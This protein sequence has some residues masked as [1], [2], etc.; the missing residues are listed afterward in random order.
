MNY[1]IA[2]M[3][4]ATK[5]LGTKEY[6]GKASNAVVESFFARAGHPGLKDDVPWC[7]AFTGAVLAEC[8]VQGS[9]SLMARS[10]LKWGKPV[11]RADA[12][13]GDVV[14]LERGAP[15]SGHVAFFVRW[16]DDKAVLRGGN[17]GDAVNDALF[18]AAKIIG[19]RRADGAMVQTGRPT[20][21]LGDTGL[22]V[23]ELQ[24]LLRER[25]YFAGKI[26]GRFGALTEA[27][28]LAFQA[29]ESLGTDGVVGPKTWDAI[30]KAEARPE[31][32]VT[33]E[34]LREA[35]S[36]QIKTADKMKTVATVGGVVATV[37]AVADTVQVVEKPIQIASRLVN[38]HWPLL[39]VAVAAAAIYFLAQKIISARVQ[40]ARSGA[41]L[42]R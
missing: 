41:H 29:Y 10:Y 37:T 26:D 5:Y 24:E 14:I 4:A 31:R 15:P 27:A 42:G 40:D 3:D 1:N 19:I 39:L 18:S 12:M 21:R 2:I 20:L 8:G 13:P 11:D 9:G 33:V 17:Q 23:R 30:L 34:E 36:E 32:K 7:A 22:A 38:E 25:N 16:Q 28:V 6:P 35:G